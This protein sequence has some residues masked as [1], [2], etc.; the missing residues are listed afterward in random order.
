LSAEDGAGKI[1]AAAG[2]CKL[3]IVGVGMNIAGALGYLLHAD[4]PIEPATIAG[5]LDAVADE[6]VDPE[7][8]TAVIPFAEAFSDLFRPVQYD[9]L[10]ATGR[11]GLLLSRS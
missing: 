2:G 11:T 9:E 7:L 10:R 1:P 8:L 3:D 4:K 6:L 5:A